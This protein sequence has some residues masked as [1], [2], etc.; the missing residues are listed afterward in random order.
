MIY[1]EIE[2]IEPGQFV[3]VDSYGANDIVNIRPM[4][5]NTETPIGIMG[6]DHNLIRHGY[7]CI[8]TKE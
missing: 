6:L 3:V 8:T 1:V 4:R 7:G 2:P 5:N